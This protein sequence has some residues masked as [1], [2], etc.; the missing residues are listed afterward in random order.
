MA[1]PLPIPDNWDPIDPRYIDPRLQPSREKLLT[2]AGAKIDESMI[3]FKLAN[4]DPHQP[5][6]TIIRL[7]IEAGKDMLQVL[8]GLEREVGADLPPA[9]PPMQV[10]DRASTEQKPGAQRCVNCLFYQEGD[11]PHRGICRRFPPRAGDNVCYWP[12]VRKRD[13]CGFWEPCVEDGRRPQID[14]QDPPIAR[15]DG[16]VR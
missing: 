3:V 9:F 10:E 13:W 11:S 12:A 6:W 1:D 8:T 2:D 16:R 7:L 15:V 5:L 4:I 14:A